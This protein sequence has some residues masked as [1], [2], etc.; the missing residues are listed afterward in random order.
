MEDDISIT[1]EMLLHN[2]RKDNRVSL[3]HP[4]GWILSLGKFRNRPSK[5]TMIEDARVRMFITIDGM[6][7]SS[8]MNKFVSKKFGIDLD[9]TRLDELFPLLHWFEKNNAEEW[10][11]NIYL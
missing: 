2:W 10:V 11:S 4:N 9:D 7:L 3:R 6:H 8:A 1:P 5:K